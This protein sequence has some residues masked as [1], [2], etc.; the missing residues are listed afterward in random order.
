MRVKCQKHLPNVQTAWKTESVREE[1]KIIRIAFT[2]IGLLFRYPSGKNK[3]GKKNTK[4]K[5]GPWVFMSE[6]EALTRKS[7]QVGSVL[8]QAQGSSSAEQEKNHYA[9][10]AAK[11]C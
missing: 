10:R 1:G 6:P 3:R 7:Q 2:S 11:W 9:L 8:L 4:V 5:V